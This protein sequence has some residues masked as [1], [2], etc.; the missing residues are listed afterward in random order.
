MTPQIEQ[1]LGYVAGSFTNYERVVAES[2]NKALINIEPKYQNTFFEKSLSHGIPSLI[3]MYSSLYKVTKQEKYIALSNIH[4][5]KLVEIISKDGIESPSLYAGTAGISLA[6]REA[7]IS[8][9]YYTKLLSSLHCLLK[10][11]TQEKLI[12]SL[13]NIDKRII[14][15]FDYDMVNGFS[16]IVNY[17]ILER[18]YFFEEL[19]QIGTYLLKYV[20]TILYK[21]TNCSVDTK[22]ELDLGIAHGIVGP[23]LTLAKLKSERI[24]KEDVEI[25]NKAIKLV[26]LCRREDKLWPG[27]IYS[28]N[29]LN[30]DFKN[31]PTRMAWCYGTPGTALALFK[32]C[33]LMDLNYTDNIVESLVAQMNSTEKNIYS[34]SMCHG[35]SGVAFIYDLIGRSYSNV[36]LANFA[37]YLRQEIIMQFS[38]QKI[39]GYTDREKL[40]EVEVELESV[41]IL[42]GVSGIVLFLLNPYS[43]EELL[44]ERMFI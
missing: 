12:I 15:P 7:S 11:Q 6:I 27:K 32:I 14:E 36:E 8:G 41:G 3:L 31:L 2:A 17:L 42:Q 20:E 5:E 28:D 35:L 22:N 4:I 44:W 23:M 21:V 19:K 33:Q 34:P 39:F 1:I 38:E 13:S 43:D 40:G 29:I 24:L 18:E 16:G 25:L 26:F 37:D 30:F 10:E 9:K